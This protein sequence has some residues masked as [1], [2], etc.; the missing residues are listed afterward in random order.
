MSAMHEGNDRIAIVG[1]AG[2]FPGARD[3]RAFWRM[4]CDGAE[5]I[6]FFTPQELAA[7]GVPDALYSNPDHVAANGYLDDVKL[8]DA[9]FFGMTPREAELT[10][11]QHR[12]F[13][14]SAWHALEDAAHVPDRFDGPI[15]VYAGCG[16]STYLL[17]HLFRNPAVSGS[18]GHLQY[19]IGNSGDY[20]PTRVSY[21]LNL[22]GPSVSINTACSTSLVAVHTACQALL[23]LECDMALAGGAAVQLPQDHG[24]LHEANTI[25]SPDGHC[26]AFDARAGGTVG[27]N[28]VGVVA[29]RRLEDA[30]ADGDPI[31]AV[32]LGSAIN[33][34]GADKVGYTAPSVSGQAS[35]IAEAL[36]VSDID[37][38]TIQYIE[39]HGTGTRVG[40]PIEIQAL[41]RAFDADSREQ[42]C[43]LGSVKTNIG[44]LDE[45]AGVAGLIK[46]VLSLEQATLPPS[47]HFESLNPQIDLSDSPFYINAT[48]RPWPA[49]DRPPRAGVSSFGIGGTNAH[50]VLEQAPTVPET[51]TDG[52]YTVPIS[53][54]SAAA[55]ERACAALA[56]HLDSTP[57]LCATSVARTMQAGR[58][59]FEFR[60]AVCG[61]TLDDLTRELRS[62]RA[63]DGPSSK[64]PVAF[65]FPGQ[66]SQHVQMAAELYAAEPFFRE[67]LDRCTAL[68]KRE[69]CPQTTSFL[70]EGQSR[71]TELSET[72]HTQPVL[73][74]IEFCLA[75]LWQHW[76]MTADFLIG[77][78]LGE[79]VAA[80]LAGVFDLDDAIRLVVA[81]GRLMQ[82]AP[83]GSMLALPI[84]AEEAETYLAPGLELA[85]INS[86]NQVV[87][88]GPEQTIVALEKRLTSTGLTARRLQTSHA[89]HSKLM[90]PAAAAFECVLR[91]VS[92]A[93]PQ[94]PIV[95]NVTGHQLTDREAM[96]PEYWATHLRQTVRFADGIDFLVDQ[97]CGV[98]L[99]VG[100][101]NVLTRLVATH[102]SREA[103]VVASLPH[104]AQEA[105]D[106]ECLCR[107][108]GALWEAGVDLDW[109]HC[110]VDRSIPRVSLPGYAFAPDRHWVDIPR[111]D[112][113]A[114]PVPSV[115]SQ[116]GATPT[117]AARQLPASPLPTPPPPVDALPNLSDWFYQPHWQP[118]S[119]GQPESGRHSTCLLLDDGSPLAARVHANLS[120]RGT[121][122]VCWPLSATDPAASDGIETAVE[123]LT[124]PPDLVV[125]LWCLQMG[126]QSTVL[127][128]GFHALLRLLQ[129]LAEKFVTPRG[130]WIVC[131]PASH[132]V[133]GEEDLSPVHAT[134]SGW[135]EAV[136]LEFPDLDCRHV[137]LDWHVDPDCDFSGPGTDGDTDAASHI[138]HEIDTAQPGLAA[139]RN[140]VRWTRSWLQQPLPSTPSSTAVKGQGTYLITG[141]LG[142]MGM[143]FAN[144]LSR[145]APCHLILTGRSP[146]P[147]QGTHVPLVDQVT[148]WLSEAAGQLRIQTLGQ[149]AGLGTRLDE[150]CASLA[151]HQLLAPLPSREGWTRDALLQALRVQPGF[152][153]LLD[154]LLD[155]LVDDGWLAV[156]GEH[157]RI[158][159]SPASPESLMEQL[160]T[161]HATYLGLG[162]LL[163]H[164]ADKLADV[165]DG[166]VDPLEVLYPDGTD[167]MFTEHTAGVPP[168][169]EDRIYLH[170]VGRLLR[171]LAD[172]QT[173][174]PVRILEVG[175][176]TG[177]LTQ[178]ALEA[179]EGVEVEY[180][181]TDLGASFVGRARKVAQE[182]GW[183]SVRFAVLDISEDPGSQGVA[184]S[185]FDVV[186]G[187]NVV[188]TA[189]DICCAVGHLTQV[190]IEDG[191]LLLIET[192]RPSRLDLMIWGLTQ[193]WWSYEDVD[194]R[195]RT[196]ILSLDQWDEALQDEQI[197]VVSFPRSAEARRTT[198][199]GLIVARPGRRIEYWHPEDS[200]PG[201]PTTVREIADIEQ[202]GCS[203]QYIRG[204]ISEQS[205]LQAIRQCLEETGA[206]LD[207]IIHTAG[208]LGQG[209]I[210]LKSRQDVDR[211][212]APKVVA[213]SI[214][215][216][217]L[218]EFAPSFMV[219]CSSLSSIRPVAGQL[220]YAAANAFLDAYAF[221]A[222]RTGATRV[223]SVTWGFW[224]E[225]GMVEK[226]KVDLTGHRELAARIAR[227]DLRDAGVEV[228]SRV[229]ENPSSAQ[230][231]VTPDRTA[232][233]AP[234][235]IHPWFERRVHV[236]D[237]VIYLEGTLRA[238]DWVVKEHVVAGA[239]VLPGTAYLE[240]A[241]AAA[242]DVDGS[243]TMELRQVYFLRPLVIQT[244]A[245]L[246]VVLQRRNHRWDFTVI[247]AS[248]SD[249]WLE[250]ARGEIHP[251][252]D[253]NRSTP[254]LDLEQLRMAFAD[255]ERSPATRTDTLEQEQRAFET[256]MSDFGPRWH[257]LVSAS[258]GA[259]QAL[260]EFALSPDYAGEA[261]SL[262]LHP[263]LL[264]NATGFLKVR[265][266]RGA[267]VPFSFEAI[268]IH[269]GLPGH[270]VSHIRRSDDD[271]DL[272]ATYDVVITD[273][274]GRVA[275]EITGYAM[276]EVAQT[277]DL[278][279]S[280][281]EAAPANVA[282]AQDERGSLPTLY[283]APESRPVPV[284]DEIEIEILA[285]GLNFIEVLY[286]LGM[287]PETEAH[288]FPY[289]L[290]CAG[291]VRRCGP[292]VQHFEPGDEIVAFSNGC[293]RAYATASERHVARK[294]PSLTMEQGATI[295][296]AYMTAWHALTGPGRLL[297]GERVLIHSAA[298]G[299]GLAAVHVAQLLGAEIVATAGTEEKRQYLRTLGISCVAD[300]R[301]PGFADQILEA[302][303]GDG[304]DV[305]L[306]ALGP[307][308]TNESLSVLA[309]YGR[310]IEMGKRAILDNAQLEL[311]PFERQLTF[312]AVDVGPD[313]PR[314]GEA[315]EQLMAHVASGALPP[316]PFRTFP[317]SKPKEGFEYMAGGR[318]IGKIVFCLPPSGELVQSWSRHQTGARSFDELF[319]LAAQPTGAG[320]APAGPSATVSTELPRPDD[321]SDLR[322]ATEMVVA[323][324]WGDLLGSPQIDRDDSFFDL[325]GDSLLAA[326]VISRIHGQ[327]GIKLPF[328]AIFDA[329]TVA[330]LAEAIDASLPQDSE[331][332]ELEEGVI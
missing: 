244:E 295:P 16:L 35:V 59:A 66:G 155:M 206:D 70:D 184:P 192:V 96:D 306:N 134:L 122:V 230:V 82:A 71:D 101:S 293:Y 326:Q 61:A 128:R 303:H 235:P 305:V 45:A 249:Q 10:D 127:T 171:E 38:Q 304:V 269:T 133:T 20:L 287:L 85:S 81:R 188:H 186:V 202:R 165:L 308:F 62:R 68:L 187:Y 294:P 86:D 113:P 270:V 205:S 37:P 163:R 22:T 164:C 137:D 142:S 18:A 88:S 321:E 240:L 5:G 170:A 120:D 200:V 1:M 152:E 194:L 301:Q 32:I 273:L 274:Q 262:C 135:A 162:R 222:S 183:D 84:C 14:Q 106:T 207:G 15:G 255:S 228:L 117:T 141:G 102:S 12:L 126:T 331:D 238:T 83:A 216:Q 72:K 89:F 324:I 223:V 24:Y 266:Q 149:V 245:T 172:S 310:F 51:V 131:T 148:Q 153:R 65:M 146:L 174:G 258:F 214:L 109:D 275:V 175:G 8:F 211:T 177:E 21:R 279:G 285:V 25:T 307:Q 41:N 281:S 179:L 110:G 227:S 39:T 319:G 169:T 318:H 259:G 46:T 278:P 78:S 167:R 290:E 80:C 276:R 55:V 327:L 267:T 76:G 320:I 34:D 325:H 196:P 253:S 157:L 288:S 176:G 219:L 256:D 53:A 247:C 226:A 79:L 291:I 64:R 91:E 233:P 19:L 116:V 161:E 229:L 302:T 90:E 311:R 43:A 201:I 145:Q 40:D 312:A 150:L 75:R 332:D 166:T 300:S 27:G 261:E 52:F 193:G 28:G 330:Q 225:L 236:D 104:P 30:L 246:R 115:A 198:A 213:A 298:G 265:Q 23:N 280:S 108:Q 215:D 97:H 26:R 283:L 277:S 317:A 93:S 292:E 33:N 105:S 197:P 98:F 242:H 329:P 111:E 143:A 73:F 48:L 297:Q 289:G 94:I 99:E 218:E 181:F 191:L 140:G 173:T 156:N 268:R 123:A 241:R 31:R 309:P 282:L 74:A 217:L 69:G 271:T 77:H 299:V 234:P 257:N 17:F 195:N 129:A 56:D 159:G 138:L 49:A 87:L 107:A 237:H 286:C 63:P 114:P 92:L 144:Y 112:A 220:D 185:S 315:W 313:L 103:V 36:S 57:K 125:H 11:P 210:L 67:Q 252:Q 44:H 6:R 251:G 42:A 58:K 296:A 182:R 239:P 314:F 147:D 13:L 151:F 95:S 221:A 29:L 9:S 328:S 254:M 272:A 121:S 47:L 168:L 118:D 263:A 2:R 323:R 232:L 139:W 212:F 7:A 224:Q 4:L 132:S 250:H 54:R 260:G 60:T 100:P 231:V 243:E 154:G 119:G 199:A 190:L 178:I 208:E 180:T 284:D 158:V 204:D 50:V 3:V 316:L 160:S 248:E 203:V 264:D 124:E 130:R 209:S 322:S 189:P 136:P